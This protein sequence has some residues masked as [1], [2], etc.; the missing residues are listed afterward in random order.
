MG[1][2]LKALFQPWTYF[3]SHQHMKTEQDMAAFLHMTFSNASFE[4]KL[5]YFVVFN[6]QWWDLIMLIT[7]IPEHFS[8]IIL[9][10]DLANERRSYLEM[11]SL[12]EQAH[13]RNDPHY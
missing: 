10:T 9:V 3:V 1:L 7:N 11:S 2:F 8:G 4:R 12:I 13:S 6:L 5:L